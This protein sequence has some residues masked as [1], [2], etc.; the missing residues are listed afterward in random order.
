MYDRIMVPMEEDG[1]MEAVACAVPLARQLRCPL[2]LLHVHHPREAP[3]ELEG[4]TQFRYQGVVERW[5]G[6]DRLAEAHELEWLERLA[7]GVS[8]E[9]PDL[10]VS[11][12]V[13]HAPIS[14]GI[15]QNAEAV[16]VVAAVDEPGS[17]PL[18]AS[19]QMLLAASATPIVMVRPHHRLMSLRRIMVAL[20]GSR[21]SREAVAPAV[22]LARATGARLTLIEVVT[23]AAGI[24][25]LLRPGEPSTE[26]AAHF[27]EAIRSEIPE[28]VGPVDVRVVEDRSADA[29][30]IRESAGSGVDLVV[31]ATHGRGGLR[32]FIMGSIAERVLEGSDIPVLLYRPVG[33]ETVRAEAISALQTSPA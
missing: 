12:R 27:L 28:E 20:D 16:L 25:G 9:H 3:A 13:V 5:D 23:R 11:S 24:V 2:T 10:T 15:E 33:T 26:S 6:I 22:R 7:A 17:K 18:P 19:V 32:R 31:M 1:G 30:L 21:F 14:G 29:G 8:E 4:L